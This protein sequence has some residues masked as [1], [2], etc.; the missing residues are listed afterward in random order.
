VAVKVLATTLL[1]VLIQDKTAALAAVQKQ[2]LEQAHQVKAI[3]AQPQPL[4]QQVAVVVLEARD[5]ILLVE[6]LHHPALMERLPIEQVAAVDLQHS[7]VVQVERVAAVVLEMA[8]LML[9][10]IL[11]RQTLEAVEVELLILEQQS[12]QAEMVAQEL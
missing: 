2:L 12:A 8:L 1:A 3:T 5:L 11:Q 4:A 7:Q 10:A 9:T 6:V